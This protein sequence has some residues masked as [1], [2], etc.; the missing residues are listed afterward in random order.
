MQRPSSVFFFFFFYRKHRTN[1]KTNRKTTKRGK[2][3][4]RVEVSLIFIDISMWEARVPF[5][6]FFFFSFHSTCSTACSFCLPNVS[7]TSRCQ[8]KLKHE[9]NFTSHYL[10]SNERTF[11]RSRVSLQRYRK[12]EE[13]RD[14]SRSM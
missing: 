13:S 10:R 3:L 8:N 11:E 4:P 12:I 14:L 2:S 9:R 5:L 7:S 1:L 6:L